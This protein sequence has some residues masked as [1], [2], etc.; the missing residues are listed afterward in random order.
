MLSLIS[1]PT[2]RTAKAF[3]QWQISYEMKIILPSLPDLWQHHNA[4]VPVTNTGHSN[5]IQN[6]AVPYVHRN[7]YINYTHPF[8]KM[9]ATMADDI[10][11]RFLEL[12]W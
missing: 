9:A 6:I 1:H 11:N 7:M 12:K 8:G 3:S 10:L 4:F 2:Q 5:L